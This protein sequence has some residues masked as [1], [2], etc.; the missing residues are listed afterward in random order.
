MSRV[1]RFCVRKT[2][3]VSYASKSLCLLGDN[4]VISILQPPASP[5]ETGPASVAQVNVAGSATSQNC[6]GTSHPV[7]EEVACL[8]P[9]ANQI[10]IVRVAGQTNSTDEFN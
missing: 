5:S 1:L 7:E 2:L 8:G 9:N 3:G 4:V 6:H 10:V